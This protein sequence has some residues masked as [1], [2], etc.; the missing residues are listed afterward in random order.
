MFETKFSQVSGQ[1]PQLTSQNLPLLSC[2]SV[3]FKKVATTVRTQQAV[4]CL[5]VVF[6][7]QEQVKKKKK[8]QESRTIVIDVKV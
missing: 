4:Q 2:L 5:L 1:A 8:N 7:K 6:N 3:P